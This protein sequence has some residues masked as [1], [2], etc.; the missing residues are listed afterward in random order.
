VGGETKEANGEER[1]GRR[2]GFSKGIH[3]GKKEDT[4]M[5]QYTRVQTRQLKSHSYYRITKVREKENR[6][7]AKIKEMGN[8]REGGES[9]RRRISLCQTY[10]LQP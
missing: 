1:G 10:T 9:A 2:V 7:G 6:F 4:V 5:P 3:Q 8:N